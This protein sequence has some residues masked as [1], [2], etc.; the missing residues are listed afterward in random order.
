MRRA[1]RMWPSRWRRC[2][3]SSTGTSSLGRSSMTVDGRGSAWELDAGSSG[4]EWAIDVLAGHSVHQELEQLRQVL[5][6]GMAGPFTD[7]ELLLLTA[8][9]RVPEMMPEW[10]VAPG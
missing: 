7:Q 5:A 8:R 3:L 9:F 4:V 1:R 10:I 2:G 6:A